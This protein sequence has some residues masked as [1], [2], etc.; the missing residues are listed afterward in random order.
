MIRPIK[1]ALASVL[2]GALLLAG[3]PAQAQST[4]TVVPSPN[5]PGDNLL[6]G[7]D[8]SD[9]SHVWAVGRQFPINGTASHSLILRHDGTAWRTA[10]QTGFP[11]NNE[12]YGVDAVTANDAWAV[13]DQWLGYGGGSRTL[14]AHWN[15]TTWAAESTPN[16]NSDSLNTLA[17]VAAVP[18][19]PGSVWAVGISSDAAAPASRHALILRRVGGTWRVVRAPRLSDTDYLSAVDATGP[20]DAWAVGITAGT[21]EFSAVPLVLRWN[22]SAW[23]QMRLPPNPAPGSTE[24]Y[25]VEALAPNDV[26]VVGRTTSNGYSFVPYAA[27]FDGVSW[28][29]VAVPSA[30]YDSNTGSTTSSRCRPRHLRGGPYR[31][32]PNV[33]RALERPDLDGRAQR[34]QRDAHRCGRG[35]HRN[36]VGRWPPLRVR[37]LLRAFADRPLRLSAAG[38]GLAEAS[39]TLSRHRLSA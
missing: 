16:A 22:G 17:A 26:W 10:P 13:G 15:G 33:R 21:T 2:A 32:E 29:Q 23:R 18:G 37:Q 5:E 12:L 24:L 14:V 11:P 39:T 3:G 31:P 34:I 35:R 9:A 30:L 28:R 27:H 19:S 8:A 38:A 4:W 7:V 6:T 1:V 36:G 25:G 20:N